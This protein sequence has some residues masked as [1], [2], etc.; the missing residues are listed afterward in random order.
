MPGSTTLGYPYPT[1]TDK[2]QVYPAK[3]QE[4]AQAVDDQLGMAQQGSTNSGVLVAATTKTVAVVFA[5]PFPVGTV[6]V[7]NATISGGQA[8]S[9]ATATV[10]SVTRL[11][12]NLLFRRETLTAAMDANWRAT[13]Q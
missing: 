1:P 13:V 2:P 5:T 7:V 3:A 10:G 6:P 9:L 4:L 8:G 11:G 12:F